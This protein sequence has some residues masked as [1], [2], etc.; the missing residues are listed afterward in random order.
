MDIIWKNSMEELKSSN[1]KPK[2]KIFF[3]CSKCHKD[4]ML[5]YKTVTNKDYFICK[6]CRGIETQL[7]LHKENPNYG[8]FAHS[9]T[10]EWI[11]S[12]EF[13]EKRKKTME[14]KW[15][16]EYTTQSPVLRKQ[17]AETLTDKLGENYYEVIQQHREENNLKNFGVRIKGFQDEESKEKSK[18]TCMEKYGY[19]YTAQVPEIR[20]K[21]AKSSKK[22]WKINLGTKKNMF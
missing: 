2:D 15:G 19:E 12:K 13:K 7:K 10:A 9:G 22:K 16:C 8:W 4:K 5:Y 11:T 6:A 18:K 17:I 20:E 1:F 21:Q 14:D 3:V